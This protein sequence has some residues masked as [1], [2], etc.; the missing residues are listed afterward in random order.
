MRPD[1]TFFFD[2]QGNAFRGSLFLTVDGQRNGDV[3]RV[4]RV[5]CRRFSGR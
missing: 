4:I 5:T 1:Y 3:N 2:A